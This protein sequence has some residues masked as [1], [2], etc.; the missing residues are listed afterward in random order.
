MGWGTSFLQEI[1]LIKN[2]AIKF[3]ADIFL[4]RQTFRTIYEI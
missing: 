4:N 2:K 1:V 3:V